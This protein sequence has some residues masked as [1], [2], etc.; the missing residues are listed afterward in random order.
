MVRLLTYTRR[1]IGT[2]ARMG[3]GEDKGGA[4]GSD[5]SGDADDL[6]SRSIELDESIS[7][8]SMLNP[9]VAPAVCAANGAPFVFPSVEGP[10]HEPVLSYGRLWHRDHAE[11]AICREQQQRQQQQRLGGAQGRHTSGIT[12]MGGMVRPGN[13]PV[14]GAA[15]AAASAKDSPF[16][17]CVLQEGGAMGSHEGSPFLCATHHL[18]ALQES[19]AGA[20][21]AV[22][23]RRIRPGEDALVLVSGE[24]LCRENV[25]APLCQCC[26]AVAAVGAGA[27]AGADA[28]WGGGFSSSSRTGKAALAPAGM[29]ED[30]RALCASCAADRLTSDEEAG[31]LADAVRADLKAFLQLDLGGFGERGAVPVKLASASTGV[32]ASARATV[33]RN[34]MGNAAAAVDG[35]VAAGGGGDVCAEC[36]ECDECDV[37]RSRGHRHHHSCDHSHSHPRSHVKEGKEEGGGGGGGKEGGGGG[38]REEEEEEEEE[39]LGRSCGCIDGPVVVD[40]DERGRGSLVSAATAM[41]TA[42]AA[43]TAMT[44]TTATAS[45]AVTHCAPLPGLDAPGPDVGGGRMRVCIDG[46]TVMMPYGPIKRRLVRE[47]HILRGLPRVGILFFSLFFSFRSPFPFHFPVFS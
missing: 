30:G 8:S 24:V 34:A 46:L 4:A 37:G 21:C 45:P 44:S 42:T 14:Q 15:L 27:G 16:G 9:A 31:A 43:A 47:V 19:R 39:G 17:A 28:G 6:L 12:T 1:P 33:L 11:C 7:G 25:N 18:A 10:G 22:S 32:F 23:G 36:D 13:M 35:N 5:G 29:L 40:V 20:R 41:A 26:G 38:G 2:S 3:L